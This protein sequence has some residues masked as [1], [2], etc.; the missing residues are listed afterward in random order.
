VK[1]VQWLEEG[2]TLAVV[3][4]DHYKMKHYGEGDTGCQQDY[5]EKAVELASRWERKL[6][7]RNRLVSTERK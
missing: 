4:A 7:L 3:K 1:K 6:S 2:K 5:I